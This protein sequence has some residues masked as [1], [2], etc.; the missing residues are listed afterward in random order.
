MPTALHAQTNRPLVGYRG[1]QR[2]RL[3][4]LKHIKVPVVIQKLRLV[5]LSY[6]LISAEPLISYLIPQDH[7]DDRLPPS[8]LG[9]PEG[10]VLKN[11]EDDP[12][13]AAR[14]RA[15]FPRVRSVRSDDDVAASVSLDERT[16]QRQQPIELRPP[17]RRVLPILELSTEYVDQIRG[18]RPGRS[19]GIGLA[20][21]QLL[22]MIRAAE[23]IYHAHCGSLWIVESTYIQLRGT[24]ECVRPRWLG[25][26]QPSEDR[27]KSLWTGFLGQRSVQR[28]LRSRRTSCLPSSKESIRNRDSFAWRYPS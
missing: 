28:K 7:V 15:P 16:D 1:A 10:A 5:L 19:P 3:H 26:S 22:S 2:C 14:R 18:N 27:S 12:W 8:E 23:R 24:R 13:M 17:Y 11:A 21:S 20:D 4:V 25:I 6:G 9:L